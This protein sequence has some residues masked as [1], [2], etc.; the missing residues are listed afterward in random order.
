MQRHSAPKD[1]VTQNTPQNGT[2]KLQGEDK[3]RTGHHEEEQDHVPV[4]RPSLLNPFG[5]GFQYLY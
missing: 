5:T 3:L 2:H 1:G 4:S